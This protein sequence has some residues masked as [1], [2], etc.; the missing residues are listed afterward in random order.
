MYQIPTSP[1]RLLAGTLF[2]VG[3][4]G[5][6]RSWNLD[7][8]PPADTLLSAASDSLTVDLDIKGDSLIQATTSGAL[9]ILNIDSRDS[10]SFWENEAHKRL[11]FRVGFAGNSP[12]AAYRRNGYVHVA[13]F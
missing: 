7:K 8:R 11:I 1:I 9:N 5:A 2:S 4:D 3:R 6:V 13:V 10:F 12:V